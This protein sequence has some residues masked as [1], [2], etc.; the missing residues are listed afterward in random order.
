MTSEIHISLFRRTRWSLMGAGVLIGLDGVLFGSFVL[1]ILA[2]PIWFLAALIKALI[3]RKDWRTSVASIAIPLLTLALLYGNASLQS[4]M[5]RA[6][7]EIIIE[8]SE[9]Y[10]VAT[11]IYPKVLED[12]VPY[13]LDAVP[14]AKYALMFGEFM[15]HSTSDGRHSLMWVDIPPF[16]RPYYILEEARWDYMD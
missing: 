16:G 4:K 1:S 7:A 12:L 5:A 6:N 2:C 14:R 8:A 13:Q 3:Y 9:K 11:G 15:Y 10:L